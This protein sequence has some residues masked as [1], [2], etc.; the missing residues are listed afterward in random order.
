MFHSS[1][2]AFSTMEVRLSKYV[3]CDFTQILSPD[4]QLLEIKMCFCKVYHTLHRG[5]HF[6]LIFFIIIKY[7]YIKMFEMKIV[8]FDYIYLYS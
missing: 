1:Q 7:T 6:L 4:V 5:M 3:L 8:C 2:G